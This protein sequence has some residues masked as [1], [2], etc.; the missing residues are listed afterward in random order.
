MKKILISIAATVMAVLM[1]CSCSSNDE[2]QAKTS[3]LLNAAKNSS[4][5]FEELEIIE[6]KEIKYTY[7]IEEDWYE[8]FSAEV[9]GNL[10]FADEM[11]F[12]KASSDDNVAKIKEA[13]EDRLQN[14]KNTLQSYAPLEYD[15]LCNSKVQT[16][17]KYV[18]MIVGNDTEEA[19][20]AVKEAF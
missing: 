19:E 6:G 8:D 4:S 9:S 16:N 20:K 17:G 14:R 2:S 10:A 11:V 3:D 12:V 18:Y 1:M 5:S 7:D 15:K 13:L